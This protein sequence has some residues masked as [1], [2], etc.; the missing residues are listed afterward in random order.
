[1]ACKGIHCKCH[2]SRGSSGLAWLVVVV[3]VLVL[4][5]IRPIEHAVSTT[6]HIVS[7]VITIT[8]II[9]GAVLVVAATTGVIW[10]GVR[11]HRWAAPHFAERRAERLSVVAEVILLPDVTQLEIESVRPSSSSIRRLTVRRYITRLLRSPCC[12]EWSCCCRRGCRCRCPGL[13]LLVARRSI[14][15]RPDQPLR[16]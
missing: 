7:E 8:M 10:A 13:Q 1:M 12:G 14:S 2:G 16:T 9:V 15:H 11:L 4:I 6:E 5:V 3:L